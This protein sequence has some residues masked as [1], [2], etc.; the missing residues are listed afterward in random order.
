MIELFDRNFD[1]ES[2]PVF[3]EKQNPNSELDD[4]L[5]KARQEGFDAGRRVGKLDAQT[6]FDA[7]E[8]ERLT[9]EREQIKAQ[10]IELVQADANQAYEAER[11]I[12]EMFL[13]ITDRLVPELL[14][15]YGT[16]LAVARIRESVKKARTDPILSIHAHP[17]VV[18]ALEEQATTWLEE[19]PL[20]AKVNIVG[21]PKMAAGAAQVSWKAGRLNYDIAAAAQAM[22]EALEIAAKQLKENNKEAE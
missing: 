19:Q 17:D 8:A 22:R 20:A 12:V 10:L 11:D 2:G 7:T 13:G 21:D 14:A 9:Q 18:N 1:S 15:Q 16:D 5:A 3:T 6:E 4:K